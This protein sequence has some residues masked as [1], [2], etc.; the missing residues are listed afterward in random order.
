MHALQIYRDEELVESTF[1]KR[2]LVVQ[3]R[4]RNA[5]ARG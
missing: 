5:E 4:F 2:I 1:S 3:M